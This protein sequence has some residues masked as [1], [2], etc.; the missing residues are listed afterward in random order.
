MAFLP[1]SRLWGVLA[2]LVACLLLAPVSFAWQIPSAHPAR[3]RQ[4]GFDWAR[5]LG[6]NAELAYTRSKPAIP[7]GDQNRMEDARKEYEEA[8]STYRQSAQK[9]PETYLPYVAA[10][11]NNLGILDSEENRI[12]Q[13]RM[14]YAEALKIYRELA[15]KN[16]DTYLPHVAT[17][18]NNLGILDASQNRL[19]AARKEHEEALETYL[20][21]YPSEQ[22]T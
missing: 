14:K 11:L 1:P 8:L 6:R 13:A 19:N 10:T 5:E 21:L 12:A 16:P 15:Q 9:D 7:D 17:T 18:L 2:V 22:P 4:I 3:G 20:K